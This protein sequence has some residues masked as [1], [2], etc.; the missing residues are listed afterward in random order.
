MK[1]DEC[2]DWNIVG[3]R[4]KINT[5]GNTW[6]VFVNSETS[7]K[8]SFTK[9]MLDWMKIHIDGDS[10]GV[11]KLNRMPFRDE[12]RDIRKVIG[13]RPSTKLTEEGRALLK[14]RF[15]NAYTE[16]VSASRIDLNRLEVDKYQNARK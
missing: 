14:N 1:V 5:D 10:E 7:R 12:A 13:L 15:K 8:W 6:Y 2:G 4:G 11:L 16:G 3:V 9:K